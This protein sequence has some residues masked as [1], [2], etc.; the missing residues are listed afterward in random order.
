MRFNTPAFWQK[1]HAV[2]SLLLQP[3]ACVYAAL[4]AWRNR[5]TQPV[6][7]SRSIICIG[8]VTAGGA[9]KTPVAISVCNILKAQGKHP[10]FLSRGY[11]GQ[12]KGPHRVDPER[13]TAQEVGDEPLLLS[14]HAPAWIARNRVAGAEAAIA[15]GAD[16][17]IM[18]DGFQNPALKKDISLLVI[19]GQYGLGN[20][21]LLPAG[22]LRER[23]A[24]ALSRTQAVVIMGEDK[25][26]ISR[27][28][29]SI[30]PIL[31]ATLQPSQASALEDKPYVAFAGIGNPQKFFETLKIMNGNV[32]E[33]I[34]FPD[35]YPYTPEDISRLRARAEVLDAGLVTTEKDWVRLPKNLRAEI[36]YVPVEVRWE[37]EV[38]LVNIIK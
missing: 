5:S 33:T 3:I 14:T 4:G 30:I 16:I 19:D 24:A 23:L 21:H 1:N 10:A 8:N 25:H 17:I 38:G 15:A 12:Y 11:G 37:N 20:G 22:P 13:D 18:D 27:Q 29:P 7:L 31:H 34:S 26:N 2:V 6:K 35:H 9:G 32:A 28:I 36:R